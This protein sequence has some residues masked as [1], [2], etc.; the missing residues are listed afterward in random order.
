MGG[1][2][3]CD[4]QL[5]APRRSSDS[6]D[7]VFGDVSHDGDAD[8]AG[9]VDP[10]QVEEPGAAAQMLH[11][12]RVCVALAGRAEPAKAQVIKRRPGTVICRISAAARAFRMRVP[13]SSPS[14][15]CSCT[16]RASSSTGPTSPP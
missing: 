5:A 8:A 1:V 14:R 12:R 6:V 3:Y 15:R 16:N 2:A 4:G 10:D 9:G 13:S 7:G 11:E